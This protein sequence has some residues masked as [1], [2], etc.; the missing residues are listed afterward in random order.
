MRRS[1]VLATSIVLAGSACFDSACTLVGCSSGLRIDFNAPP[2]MPFRLEASSGYAGG[3]A[4]VFEC[5]VVAQCNA[6]Y[7]FLTDYLPPSATIKLTT[8]AGTTTLDVTPAYGKFQPNGSRCG[9]TCT[10]A[11]VQIHF[12]GS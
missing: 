12:P 1:L 11:T 5:T 10:V 2:T 9:P 6:Q 7:V 8:A 4:Y 3:P